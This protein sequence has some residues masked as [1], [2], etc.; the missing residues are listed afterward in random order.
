MRTVG[1]WPCRFRGNKILWDR[2]ILLCR[3]S[4]ASIWLSTCTSPSKRQDR[5]APS[6]DRTHRCPQPHGHDGSPPT[7]R[8]RAHGTEPPPE[9]GRSASFLD[10]DSGVEETAFIEPIVTGAPTRVTSIIR[11]TNHRATNHRAMH[12]PAH[13]QSPAVKEIQ[14]RI[15]TMNPAPSKTSKYVVF[16]IMNGGSLTGGKMNNHLRKSWATSTTADLHSKCST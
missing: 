15:I 16:Q 5:I 12:Q 2:F 14:C 9:R 6:W 8:Q 13:V 4:V 7:A 10:M 1:N 3:S 11:A